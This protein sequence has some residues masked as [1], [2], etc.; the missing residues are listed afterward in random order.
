M[1]GYLFPD[2][3]ALC[4]LAESGRLNELRSSYDSSGRW[5]AGTAFEVAQSAG[6]LRVL[7][8][9]GVVDWLGEPIEI[10]DPAEVQRVQ[11]LRR[12]AFG[13]DVADPL[14]RLGEAETCHVLSE[15]GEF[16]GAIWVTGDALVQRYAQRRGIRTRQ[17]RRAGS[18]IGPGG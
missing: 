18:R 5:T 3:S 15:W 10:S 12:A 11:F 1:S 13:G 14:G 2:L 6:R 9:A 17:V 7:A 4:L 8:E 16:A